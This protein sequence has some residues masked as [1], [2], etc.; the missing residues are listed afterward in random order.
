[1]SVSQRLKCLPAPIRPRWDQDGGVWYPAPFTPAGEPTPMQEW[2]P[3]INAICEPLLGSSQH[4]EQKSE[5]GSD[6]KI[7]FFAVYPQMDRRLRIYREALHL[8][9]VYRRAADLL[10][11]AVYRRQVTEEG[12]IWLDDQF[13]ELADGFSLSRDS[14]AALAERMPKRSK[15][16]RTCLKRVHLQD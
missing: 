6:I 5:D 9:R 13:I 14:W 4:Y 10:M 12:D 1:M 8:V 16:R 7:R 15:I 3:T 11:L 2:H